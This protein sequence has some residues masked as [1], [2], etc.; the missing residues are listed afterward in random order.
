MNQQQAKSA[1]GVLLELFYS[2]RKN[3]ELAILTMEHYIDD[4][5]MLKDVRTVAREI[6]NQQGFSLLA[7][8][9]WFDMKAAEQIE[10][11]LKGR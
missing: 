4:L 6:E 3:Q 10:D 5:K 1:I 9:K 2:D 8:M 7:P 11:L